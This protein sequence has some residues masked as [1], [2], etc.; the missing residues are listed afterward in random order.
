MLRVNPLLAFLL[1]FAM[2]LCACQPI[3]APTG[4]MPTQSEQLVL[5]PKMVTEIEALIEQ[6]MADY[7]IP[8][9]AIGIIKDGQVVY[10]NTLGLAEYDTNRPITTETLFPVA[11]LSKQFT[12]AAIMQLVEEGKVKLDAPVVEYL[13]YFEMADAQYSDITIRQLLAHTSGIPQIPMRQYGYDS[14][15]PGADALSDYV[16]SLGNMKLDNAPG[17][18]WNYSNIGYN[19]LGDVIANVSGESYERYVKTHILDPLGMEHSTFLLEEIDFDE[20]SKGHYLTNSGEMVVIDDL[21]HTRVYAP[22]AGLVTSLSDLDQWAAVLSNHGELDGNRV[23]DESTVNEMWSPVAVLD[24][25]D[26]FQDYALGW[27][28]AELEGHR[29]VW[30][31]GSNPGFVS[32]L[33]VAPEDGLAVVTLDNF[34]PPTETPPY[35]ATDVGNEVMLMLL[36]AE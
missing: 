3:V 20:L 31:G 26:F 32:N 35:H 7:Q 15:D 12:A 9:F 27:T 6:T 5:D 8:G 17:E 16:R 23:L 19:V 13:P 2:L 10:T 34:L 1:V 22:A 18:T 30:H 28:V 11:S 29:L 21:P 36:A 4:G 25:G 14:D 33:I 24:W